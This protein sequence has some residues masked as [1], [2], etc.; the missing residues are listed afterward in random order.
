MANPSP[1]SLSESMQTALQQEPY[2][3][4]VNLRAPSWKT[5]TN[6]IFKIYCELIDP[7]N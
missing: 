1:A 2:F 3:E 4:P 5:V 7:R 6:E